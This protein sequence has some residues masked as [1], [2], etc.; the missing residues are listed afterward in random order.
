VVLIGAYG[1]APGKQAPQRS[2]LAAGVLIVL[3]GIAIFVVP[4]LT[5]SA[6]CWVATPGPTGIAYEMTDQMPD[7][8]GD[9]QIG[10]GCD[11][12][13]PS[14]VAFPIAIL[15]VGAALALAV[16]SSNAGRRHAAG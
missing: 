16:L 2:E 11:S 3:L 4:A 15:L 8:L 1:L 7:Q 9:G 5:R 6:R 12:G 13:V 14:P 10:A